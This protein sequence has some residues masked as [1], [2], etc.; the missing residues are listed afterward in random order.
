MEDLRLNVTIEDIKSYFADLRKSV[1]G[2]PNHFIWN[3]DELGHQIWADRK[4]TVIVIPRTCNEK[5]IYIPVP[6]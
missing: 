1:H 6:R 3:M 4:S 2:V 5:T